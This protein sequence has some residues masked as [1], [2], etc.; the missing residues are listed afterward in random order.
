MEGDDSLNETAMQPDQSK[1]EDLA[2]YNISR[3]VNTVNDLEND[4]DEDG[5]S[6]SDVQME[7]EGYGMFA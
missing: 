7:E 3:R 6:S 5:H 1:F 2:G 4:D